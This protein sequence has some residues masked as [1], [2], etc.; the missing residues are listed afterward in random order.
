M[1][2]VQSNDVEYN[3]IC[4]LVWRQRWFS[5]SLFSNLFSFHLCTKR[6]SKKNW[7]NE[8]HYQETE[9]EWGKKWETL[10][11]LWTNSINSFRSVTSLSLIWIRISLFIIIVE[12]NDVLIHS[13]ST[14]LYFTQ[15][16]RS[17]IWTQI[18]FQFN[19]MFHSI[20][21]SY[22]TTF[23]RS[24]RAFFAVAVV[25]AG[26]CSHS[27]YGWNTSKNQ[28]VWLKIIQQERKISL[29]YC[30]IYTTMTTMTTQQQ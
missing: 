16:T 20:H 27:G 23:S 24:L 5:F 12:S 10:Y 21:R 19:S 30:K 7:F 14:M 6:S 25:A 8:E 2:I 26:W 1:P 3:E 22:C 28:S 18:V 29:K 4:A 11:C 13:V 15:H 17:W 9:K